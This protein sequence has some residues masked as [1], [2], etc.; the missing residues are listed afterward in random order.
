[1]RIPFRRAIAVLALPALIAVAFAGTR[2]PARGVTYRIRMT[3]QLPAIMAQVNETGGPVIAARVKSVGS[4]A[5]F[6]FEAAPQGMG[7]EGYVLMLDSGRVVF[8]DTAQK[9]FAEA[10]AAFGGNGGAL[11]M[12]SQIAGASRRREGTNA[13]QVDITGLVTD[14]QQLDGEVLD[15]RQVRH[16]QLVAEMNVQVMGN[17]APLRVEME[18][19]TADLPYQIVNPFDLKGTVSPDDPM[20]KFTTKLVEM[21]KKVQGTPLKTVTNISITGLGNGA[22][23]PIEFQQTTAITDIR[24]ADVN[25]KELEVPAGFTRRVEGDERRPP[26]L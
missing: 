5:R 14:V 2:L 7:L 18:M 25:A 20:L 13:P 26:L 3:S 10:P 23:P 1:M 11:G 9:Q 22:L 17:I 15:G 16:Y 19:W 4:R 8:V 21:R 24:V 6:D 12:I